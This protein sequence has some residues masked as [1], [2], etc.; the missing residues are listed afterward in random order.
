MVS[1]ISSFH[2]TADRYI[3]YF[4]CFAELA[5]RNYLNEH[6][7]TNLIFYLSEGVLIRGVLI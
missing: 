4:T 3:T 7:G 2:S 6:R 5:Y 1:S